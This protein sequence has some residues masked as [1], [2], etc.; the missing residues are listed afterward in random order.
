MLQLQLPP[1]PLPGLCLWTPLGDCVPQTLWLILQCPPPNIFPK[2]TPMIPLP[3]LFIDRPPGWLVIARTCVSASAMTTWPIPLSANLRN[4][5]MP[6]WVMLRL[7]V[8]HDLVMTKTSRSVSGTLMDSLSWVRLR[9]RPSS[10]VMV[11]WL[12]PLDVPSLPI[13]MT[14]IELAIHPMV[15]PMFTVQSC[16]K[17]CCVLLAG[18]SRMSTQ[19]RKLPFIRK[20]CSLSGKVISGVYCRRY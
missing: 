7:M 5:A 9:R 15:I 17:F 10:P 8:F 12:G 16:C 11:H 18:F 1:D 13:G 19:H 4:M 2:F 3:L 14:C 20:L 6:M